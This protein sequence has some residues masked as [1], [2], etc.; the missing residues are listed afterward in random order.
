MGTNFKKFS[1]KTFLLML[2][3]DLQT[4]FKNQENKQLC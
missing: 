2:T 4:D 1:Q 3:L